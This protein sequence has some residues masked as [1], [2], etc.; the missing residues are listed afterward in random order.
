MKKDFC[1]KSYESVAIE[2]EWSFLLCCLVLKNYHKEDF[3]PALFSDTFWML[4][5]NKVL[6][7]YEFFLVKKPNFSMS[8]PKFSVYGLTASKTSLPTDTLTIKN[9]SQRCKELNKNYLLGN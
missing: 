7:S 4:Y 1:L 2:D 8:G 6:F 3:T 9:L 5:K